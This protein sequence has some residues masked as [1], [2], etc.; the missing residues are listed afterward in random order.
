VLSG[1]PRRAPNDI[2]RVKELAR[3]HYEEAIATLAAIMRE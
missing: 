1:N 3:A 2:G